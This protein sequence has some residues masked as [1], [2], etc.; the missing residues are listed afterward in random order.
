MIIYL[1][2][3]W[4]MVCLFLMGGWAKA[5]EPATQSTTLAV[6]AAPRYWAAFRLLP[7]DPTAK[8]FL[9]SSTNPPSNAD[10]A[11][12]IQ[13]GQASLYFLSQGAALA[14]CDWN[15][16]YSK[17]PSTLLPELGR[18]R[19]LA[20]LAS[21][22]AQE[23][24]RQHRPMEAI[25]DLANE[26]A[27]AEHLST[28]K[29]M[30]GLLVRDAIEQR[31]IKNL[32]PHLQQLDK[33][34]LNHLAERLAKLPVGSTLGEIIEME[35][36]IG[37][38]WILQRA[39]NAAAVGEPMD[40]TPIRNDLGAS[41][42]SLLASV[43]DI[44]PEDIIADVQALRPYYAAARRLVETS[45]DQHQTDEALKI[46]F[47]QY[48][49]KPLGP[50]FLHYWS[51]YFDTY[52]AGRTSLTLLQAAVAVVKEGPQQVKSF[53]DPINHRP[54][55]YRA[56]PGGFDLVSTVTYRGVPVRLRVSAG[57]IQ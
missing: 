41:G 23:E 30:I 44:S 40:W 51:H 46:L 5:V 31:V 3:K 49:S 9:Y 11:Q 52:A 7:D 36:R 29:T 50:I 39:Q 15:I 2:L 33:Q 45:T 38:K 4:F 1:R 21:L 26:M 20:E 25:D 48:A 22:R 18:G 53:V 55:E 35:S 10:A 16:D 56:I 54:L 34:S 42:Q 37:L 13:S 12:I 14:D 24:F 6:N 43:A 8:K 57:P 28:D 47:K 19:T 32:T 27:L 17:G